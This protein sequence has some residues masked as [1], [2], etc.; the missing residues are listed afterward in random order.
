LN[1]SAVLHSWGAPT[2]A[3]VPS[4]GESGPRFE[5]HLAALGFAYE[6]VPICQ[7]VR[8][9]L[10]ITDSQGMTVKLNEPGPTLSEGELKGYRGGRPAASSWRE[11]AAGVR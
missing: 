2:L 8:S 3:I 1:T 11:V 5:K 9:N 7:S 6:A 4:G 10:I